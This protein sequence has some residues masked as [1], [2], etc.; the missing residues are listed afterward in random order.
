MTARCSAFPTTSSGE[1]LMAVIELRPRVYARSC[2][3]PSAA[4]LALAGYKVPRDIEVQTD[5][6]RENSG[7]IFKLRLRDPYWERANRKI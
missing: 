3:H 4:Q 2:G 6:P 7:K 5:L 1:A